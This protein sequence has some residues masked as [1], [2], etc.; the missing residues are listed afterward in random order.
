LISE[1]LTENHI[2]I[3]DAAAEEF[4]K[5]GFEG[6]SIDAIADSIGQTKG[7]IYYYFRSKAEVFFAVYERAMTMV[8]DA[9][10]PHVTGPVCGIDRLRQ[11]ANAHLLNLMDNLAY[12]DALRQ[13]IDQRLRMRLTD[14]QRQKLNEL[15]ALR[16]NYESLFRD[17]IAEGVKDKSIR[18]LPVEIA[19]ST[20][21]GGLNAVD[22]WYRYRNAQG[23]LSKS[24]FAAA[25]TE[26]LVGGF[27]ATG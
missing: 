15:N 12:H 23:L 3:L 10:L 5:T 25:I 2:R 6:T 22:V 20:L 19:A 14:R 21:L 9:V 13:G 11:M 27:T 1:E 26:I 4:M 8:R 18:Q 16:D 7:L 24:E 17:V